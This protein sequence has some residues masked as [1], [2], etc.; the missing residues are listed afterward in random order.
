MSLDL[1]IS[2]DGP[3]MLVLVMEDL[4]SPSFT[5][6]PSMDVF[7]SFTTYYGRVSFELPPSPVTL[8]LW[9]VLLSSY[10]PQQLKWTPPPH[11]DL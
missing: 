10:S 3:L 4:L 7:C 8:D 1:V 6:G 5:W 9:C 11:P 2:H